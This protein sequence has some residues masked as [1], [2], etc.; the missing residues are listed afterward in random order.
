[1]RMLDLFSGIGGFSLAG[2]WAGMETAAFCEINEFCQK[3][4]RKNF[5]GVPIYDDVF[6][7]TRE[8]LEKDGAISGDRT[9]ELVCGGFPCQPFSVAGKQRGKEDDRHLWPE[10]FRIIQE[11]RPTWVVG[12]NVTGLIRLA[13]DDV[14]AD[15]ES[16][17]YTVRTFIIPASAVG[18]PHRRDRVWIVGYSDSVRCNHRRNYWEERQIHCDEEWYNQT[19]CTD[20]KKL[21][22]EFGEDGK[23]LADSNST[24]QQ[25]RHL[26]TISKRSGFSSR[27]AD[28]GRAERISQS[29][30]C[31]MF[32]GLSTKLDGH[33]WPAGL[34]QEQYEWEPPRVATGIK[35]RKDRLQALGNSI[36]PQ[37]AYQI[38][39]AIMEMEVEHHEP[40]SGICT[41]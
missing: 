13:L 6:A 35:H 7:V 14:L 2:S 30:V 5:P 19:A 27:G 28:Q 39:K 3:V 29:G 40:A 33:R 8:Q 23:T 22:S 1:M 36:V 21:Q 24:G 20:G 12:E 26:A 9:V 37:V 38:L 18:A 32:N 31:R 11:L 25:K 10:M 16:E 41:D 34:G 17:G 15:L 4:L